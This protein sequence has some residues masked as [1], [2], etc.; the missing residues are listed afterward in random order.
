MAAEGGSAALGIAIATA[1]EHAALCRA[2]ENVTSGARHGK[3][4][5]F[6]QPEHRL[7]QTAV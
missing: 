3:S 1:G 2:A 7:Y 4:L 5:A 6:A